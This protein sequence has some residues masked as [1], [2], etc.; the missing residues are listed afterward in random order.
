MPGRDRS[1]FNK[2]RASHVTPN[3]CFLLPVGSL[4][5]VVH[6]GKSGPSN[7]D[8]L[9]FM[10][11]WDRYGFDKMCAGTCY[12]ELVFLHLVG[13]VGHVVDFGASGV[14]STNA[15]FFMLGWEPDGFNKKRA[16]PRYDELVFCIRWDLRF[17]QCILVRPRLKTLMYYFYAQLGLVQIR[18]KT[19]WDTIRQPCVFA[20]VGICWSHSAFWCIRG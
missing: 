7:V 12:A 9:F 6:S 1:R 19:H 11:G 10:L 4:A 5:A 8:A 3:L 15:L 13:Y 20:S 18:Q 16:R 17:V 2:N 14:S